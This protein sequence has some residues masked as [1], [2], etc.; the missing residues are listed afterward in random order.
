[1]LL[2]GAAGCVGPQQTGPGART[3]AQTLSVEDLAIRLGLQIEE[4]NESFVVMK[5]AANTVIVFTH[6]DGRFFINGKPLGSVGQIHRQGD[7]VYVLETLL[8]QIRAHLRPSAQI[9]PLEPP[10]RAQGMV[11]IDPGHG[12]RD[13]GAISVTGVYEK[14][15]NLQV[16]AKIARLL[17]QR[18]VG[19]KM[20][21]WHDH[22]VELEDRAEVANR[23]EADLFVSIH[24]DAAESRQAEGF[25]VYVA[26]AA[27]SATRRAAHS[28]SQAMVLTGAVSRGVREADYRVLVT[29]RGPAVLIELGYL[30]NP[31]EAVRLSDD[32]YQNRLA[33][34]IVGGILSYL[35]EA[36]P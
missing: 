4:R 21:R 15:V 19:V 8:L 17:E 24:A 27:S 29:T 11:V 16:A 31:R 34:A 22:F 1:L 3:G 36:P 9:P 35:Q 26:N 5:D 14:H 10:R 33:Q 13:P 20:T 32:A 28:I 25:T 23:L 12:G 6:T 7:T 18:D 2:L 30:S